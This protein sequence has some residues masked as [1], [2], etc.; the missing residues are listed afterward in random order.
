MAWTTDAV[1]LVYQVKGVSINWLLIIAPP[2][3]L[4]CCFLAVA[5]NIAVDEGRKKISADDNF[6]KYNG[7][8]VVNKSLKW[9]TQYIINELFKV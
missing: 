9:L 5:F 3:I 7:I 8:S 1:L 4:F 2:I 6:K